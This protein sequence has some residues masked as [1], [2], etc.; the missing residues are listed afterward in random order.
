MRWISIF[1]MSIFLVPAIVASATSAHPSFWCGRLPAPGSASKCRTPSMREMCF[2]VIAFV[3]LAGPLSAMAQTPAKPPGT[4]AQ[5]SALALTPEDRILGKPDAP[6]TI[7]EYASLTCPHCRHFDIDV[8]PKLKEKWVDSGKAKLVLRDYPLDEPA[9][10]AAII[11]RCFPPAQ[12][13]EVIDTIFKTQKQWALTPDYRQVLA[14]YMVSSGMKK[15]QFDACLTDKSVEDKV[16]QSELTAKQ[17]LRIRYLPSIFINGSQFD[18][19]PEFD[20]MD[21]ALSAAGS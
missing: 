17:Q 20:A 10:R 19:A 16:L 13:Y 12:F 4:T 1:R 3:T 6:I 7:V 18:G 11:A 9:K 21:A 8:L 2:A 5:A 15:D 14:Q